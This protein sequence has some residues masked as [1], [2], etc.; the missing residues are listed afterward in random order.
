MAKYFQSHNSPTTLAPLI[1]GEVSRYLDSLDNNVSNPD[2]F[3]KVSSEV[4][5]LSTNW[6]A[7]QER[8]WL[9]QVILGLVQDSKILLGKLGLNRFDA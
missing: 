8:K 2:N 4:G 3:S 1:L 7:K 9:L 5:N 6:L